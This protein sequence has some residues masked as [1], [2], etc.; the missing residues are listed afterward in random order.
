MQT[1]PKPK[2]KDERP[3]RAHEM[4]RA[5]VTAELREIL[6]MTH[7]WVADADGKRLETT[8]AATEPSAFSQTWTAASSRPSNGP[9]NGIGSRSRHSFG[10]R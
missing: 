3:V 1:K 8:L 7:L 9:P 4:R 5:A 6:G 10:R 2:A